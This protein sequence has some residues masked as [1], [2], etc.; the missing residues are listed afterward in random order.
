[1]RGKTI[2][3]L[4]KAVAGGYAVGAFNTSNMELTQAI[5]RAAHQ[6]GKP[7][8]IQVTTNGFKYASNKTF[9]KIVQAVIKYE[10]NSAEIGFHLDHG[11][12]FDDVVK[13]I[14]D[15]VDSVMIDASQMSFKENVEITTRVV[16]YAH[17]KGVTVQAELGSVPYMGR[18]DQN[19]DW[20]KIMTKPKE[21]QELVARTGVDVLAVGIGNAHGFFRELDEPDWERLK[22]IRKLIPQTPLIMH[23][24]SDWKKERVEKA[25]QFGVCCFNIDTD[26]RVSFVGQICRLVGTKCD[27]IDPRKILGPA[28]DA[29]IEKVREKIRMF[30][31]GK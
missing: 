12:S 8:I 26:I 1:M 10:S 19:I 9:G 28:R 22:E 30:R 11:K 15:G 18:E 24:T 17:S 25:I 2:E 3:I 14:D 5:A 20:E 13:A 31:G 6:E 27:I 7:C 23:G 16:D 29:V 4:Q 21:A